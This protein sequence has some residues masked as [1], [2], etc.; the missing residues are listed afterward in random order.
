MNTLDLLGRRVRC[1]GGVG[2]VVARSAP[3]GTSR[4]DEVYARGRS[5]TIR[6]EGELADRF[7]IVEEA[8][9]ERGALN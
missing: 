7:L 5:V 4:S 6:I 2:V 1:D 9:P 3:N 8:D